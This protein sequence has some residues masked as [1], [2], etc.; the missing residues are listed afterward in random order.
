[1][2]NNLILRIL[3]AIILGS[4]SI[5]AIISGGITF[6]IFVLICSAAMII[7]W[8]SMNK[9]RMSW[10]FVM[11]NFYILIPMMF[12]VYEST[13]YP[14]SLTRNILWVFSIVWTCDI[15]AYFGG[16]LLKGPKLAPTISPNKTWSGVIVGS[17]CAFIVSYIFIVK[18]MD[19]DPRLILWTIPMV[20]ASIWGDLIESKVKRILNIK[21]SG[22]I[23]PGH[24]GVCDRL[25]S[26][27]LVTY[28]FII[29]KLILL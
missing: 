21:D 19:G 11:G 27:L 16:R 15:F 10:L 26:F 13:Y 8:L 7:E 25:D 20:I 6:R 5:F 24:G 17:S 29:I 18:F 2:V 22:N 14:N 23:I 1:M 4:I 9:Q 3:S 12:W 28:V